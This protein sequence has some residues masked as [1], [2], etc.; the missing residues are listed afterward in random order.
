M[1]SSPSK[2]LVDQILM[3]GSGVA[4]GTSGAD[5]APAPGVALVTGSSSGIGA[6]IAR[7]LAARGFR[8]AVNS[9][10]SRAAGEAV[11]AECGGV[12][13]Q[14]DLSEPDAARQ[15]VADVARRLGGLDVLVNN[16]A[17]TAVV[18]LADV[19]SVTAELWQRVLG[20]NVV[21]TWTV[22]VAALPYLREAGRGAVVNISSSS[23]RRPMGSSIPYSVSKAAVEHMTRLLAKVLG[24]DVRVNA[25]APGMVDTPWT[26]GWE[27]ARETVR[28]SVPM[29]RSGVPSDIAQA[30]V[31]I[32]DN[33]YMTGSV[34]TVDGGLSLI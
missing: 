12:Y 6:E 1:R 20:L 27:E 2:H 33:P 19:E 11:A 34:V 32:V 29:R 28:R 17:T 7:S 21:G 25:L 10:S 24:P 4:A 16:A 31:A 18:P 8:V 15:L 3:A 13:F 30:C 14:A 23:A 22:T 9:S 26:E 5:D